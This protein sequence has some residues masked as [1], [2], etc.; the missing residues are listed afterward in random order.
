[1]DTKRRRRLLLVDDEPAIVET[2]SIILRRHQFEVTGANSVAAALQAISTQSFDILVTDLNI[3][4]PGDGFT[5]VSALRRT[6]PEALALIITG[7]P[8]FD[9]ALQA[10]REQV[11]DFLV[12]PIHPRD[13]VDAIEKTVRTRRVH[14]PVK[15]KRISQIVGE[16]KD[17]IVASWLLQ[18]RAL[19]KGTAQQ[20]LSDQEVLNHVAAF[21]DELCRRVEDPSSGLHQLAREA[22]ARHGE[23]RRQQGFTVGF[24]LQESTAMRRE[25]LTAIHRNLMVLDLSYLFTDFTAMSESLDDQLDVAVAA[26]LEQMSAM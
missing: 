3:G 10:I 7:F 26:Y 22:A 20:Q 8:A 9:K 5:V 17:N 24:L 18:M 11:D 13:L 1:V 19:T 6:H 2:L 14:E 15:S 25:V 16:N 23:L 12:K 21:V 4:E